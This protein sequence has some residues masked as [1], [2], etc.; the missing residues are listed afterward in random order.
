MRLPIIKWL[1]LIIFFF[2]QTA[3][4]FQPLPSNGFGFHRRGKGAVLIFRTEKVKRIECMLPSN[5]HGDPNR[6]R[7][8]DLLIQNGMIPAVAI[9]IL[10]AV[11]NKSENTRSRD[12]NDRLGDFNE[13]ARDFN[14]HFG[15]IK[16]L[17]FFS[18]VLAMIRLHME[19][20]KDG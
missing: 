12:F 14:D 20:L 16:T 11:I 9:L 13:R 17:M 15:D 8:L 10:C 6:N 1:A 18:L 7:L 19:S 2:V 4:G 5:F 3:A